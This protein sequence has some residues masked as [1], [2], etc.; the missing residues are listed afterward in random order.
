M[1]AGEQWIRKASL[2][3]ANDTDAL[4][5]SELRF[6]FHVQNADV[7]SPNNAAIR[8]YNLSPDTT[9]KITGSGA[10]E[11]TRV[12]LQAGYEGGNFGVI[13][14]GTIKQFR[15]GKENA[16]DSYLDILAADGDIPYNFGV[17]S[18]SL[19]AG[20][21]TMAR[22]R[23]TAKQIGVELLQNT[24]LTGGVL[25]RGKV[26][27]GMARSL[28]RCEARSIGATWSIQNGKV[29]IVP[30]D[31]Y[32][33]GEAVVLNSGTGLIGMPTQTDQGV[34]ARCLLNPKLRIGGLVQI[35]QASINRLSQADL[36]ALGF[37]TSTL[38]GAQLPYDRN[39]GLQMLAD[40]T[41]DGFYRLYVAEFIGDTRGQEWYSE[42]VGLAVDKSS[43]K[44]IAQ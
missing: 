31:S 29:Q 2:L 33:P 20:S 42:L 21:D 37:P 4:D 19:P 38:P 26:L 11:Y 3:V 13:F 44:V 39:T 14:D 9:R 35:D 5:L 28:L 34:R 15:Q 7:E 27:F 12:I 43:G 18:A 30:N 10:V 6:A 22:V 17:C 40:V 8:V 1:S 16:V 36:R 41:R 24:N 23:T 32:L 25:P